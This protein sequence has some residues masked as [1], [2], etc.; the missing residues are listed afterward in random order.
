MR[1]IDAD[2]L[3]RLRYTHLIRFW[4]GKVTDSLPLSEVP[5]IAYEDLVP[6]GRWDEHYGV[7]ICSNCH[8]MFDANLKMLQV[9]ATW[10]M[11]NFCPNCG[12]K[13]DLKNEDDRHDI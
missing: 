5:T 11:P 4:D 6:H 7:S 10:E 12:A 13:M 2:K 3:M 1:A 8:S 9:P